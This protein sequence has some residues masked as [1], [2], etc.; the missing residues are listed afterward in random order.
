MAVTG[1]RLQHFKSFGDTQVI[2]FAP[3]TIIFGKN[4]TG[5]S[6]LLQSLLLLRQTIDSPGYGGRLNLRGPLY[7]AGG[8]ADVVHQHDS[9]KHLAFQLN[10]KSPEDKRDGVVEL[11]F[12]ADDPQP[13]RLIRL[14]VEPFNAA[15][16]EIRRGR[17]AGGPYE[18]VID[19]ENVGGEKRANFRFSVNQFIPL[20][21]PEPPRVGRP[22]G[23]RERSRVASRQLLRLFEETLREIRAVGAFRQQ[24]D[25]RYEF[26]GRLPDVVGAAG[27]NVVDALI[28]D[29]T[30]RR[31]GGE[32]VR[33][34]N[35]WLEAVGRVRLMPI[36]SIDK[37]GRLFELRL[38][39]TDSGR[40]A[41][42]A[43][44]G[45]G[46]GQAL[47]VIVEGLR[48]PEGG[49]FLV[50]EPEIHLH[51]D[52]QLAMGDFL[53]SLVRSGRRVIL[54]THSEHILL[55]IRRAVVAPRHSKRIDQINADQ[56]SVVHVSKTRDGKSH[57][58][59]LEL[60]ELGQIHNW[61]EDFMEE[62]T[63]ERLEIMKD[64]AKRLEA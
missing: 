51:P 22:S 50:Q 44:V 41:N 37:E 40:W 13:P 31:R 46:I 63:E 56:V 23:R 57:V 6:S 53:I 17:G 48:V 12:V 38:R 18:L 25:R 32:L 49:T 1:L 36:R 7:A 8:Y 35:R 59:V 61:P 54:E 20:I 64:M 26:Q 3:I 43:D 39:D 28:A 10:L 15:H 5:K 33:G 58:R 30:R 19:G 14:K 21:G 29:A 27:E 45:F 34:V 16:M 52:A 11:E 55:R 47:P 4:N 62:A 2:P 42:F 9:S 60:D 24:P